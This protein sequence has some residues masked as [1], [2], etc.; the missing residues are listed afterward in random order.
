MSVTIKN[1]YENQRK[2]AEAMTIKNDYE[3]QKKLAETI[4]E[5]MTIRKLEVELRDFYIEWF[6]EDDDAF[7]NNWIDIFGSPEE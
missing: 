3:N 6:D 7:K 2:L 5:S 1:D 4:I